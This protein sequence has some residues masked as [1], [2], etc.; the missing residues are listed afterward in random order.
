MQRLNTDPLKYICEQFN[1]LPD[2]DAKKLD[3]AKELLPYAYARLKNVDH[4]GNLTNLHKIKIV[5][6]GDD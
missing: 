4:S 1:T 5:V 3:L 6:G 2:G